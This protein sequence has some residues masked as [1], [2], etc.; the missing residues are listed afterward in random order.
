[1][2]II[3]PEK[4]ALL[5]RRRLLRASLAAPFVLT[6]RNSFAWAHGNTLLLPSYAIAAGYTRPVFYETFDS[7]GN[8]DTTNSKTVGFSFF[9]G[10]FPYLGT[11]LTPTPLADYSVSGSVITITDNPNP[12]LAGYEFSTR[13]Y[14]GT[15][16]PRSVGIPTFS[17]GF[18]FEC[19]M[20][21]NNAATTST[22]WPTVWMQDLTGTLALADNNSAL[23]PDFGEID[24]I[25]WL[26]TGSVNVLNN[27]V[28]EWINLAR[29]NMNPNRGAGVPSA[30]NTFHTYG[31]LWKTA[32]AHGGTGTFQWY[33]DG[34]LNSA[35]QLSYSTGGNFSIFDSDNFILFMNTGPSQTMNVDYILVTQ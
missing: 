25:E 33:Y 11:A 31:F 24:M 14:L 35:S 7:I 4:P 15:S 23:A 1:M 22:G 10:T 13:A 8:I 20:S 2:S 30:S 9:T 18:Y 6:P 27:N 17:P 5:T 34:V 3:K 19:R 26:Q 16:A 28:I 21:F 12:N 29:T 32:A